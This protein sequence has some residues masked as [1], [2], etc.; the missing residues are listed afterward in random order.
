MLGLLFN[1]IILLFIVI[2]ILL[3]YSLLMISV[4]TKTFETG[5]LRLIGLSKANC[6]SMILVQSFLFVI[7]S[8]ICGYLAA[9]PMLKIIFQAIF[10]SETGIHVSC[11]PTAFATVQAL[12]LGFFIPI[13]S[14]ILPIRSMMEKQLNESLCNTRSK[15]KGAIVEISDANSFNRKLPYILSGGLGSGFGITIFFFLPLSI[16]TFNLGLMLNI[17][18]FILIGMLLGLVLIS[19]NLQKLMELFI[20]Q[21]FLFFESKSMKLL[22]LKNMSAH[23]QANKMTSIIYSLTLGCIIFVIVDS[24]LNLRLLTAGN[25][26]EIN[27]GI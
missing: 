21:V 5:V 7:P 16:L 26:G 8:I 11:L 12:I 9:I 27:Y 24:Q 15:T 3:I 4:E 1:I 22:I 14:S 6:I 25:Y 18:F 10:K 20:V 17:F 23:R 2:S 13:V 19:F